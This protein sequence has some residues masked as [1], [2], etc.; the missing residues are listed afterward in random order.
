KGVFAVLEGLRPKVAVVPG[1]RV[2]MQEL[3]TVRIGGQ[4]TK[5]QYQFTLQSP[6]PQEL[7][8][9]AAELEG[10]MR[11]LSQL[12]DVTSDMQVENPE[13]HVD[14][15]RDKASRLGIS[16]EQI[17]SALYSAYGDRWISTIF[18]PNNQY[19]VIME[20]EDAYQADPTALSL[21]YVR[22]SGGQLVPLDTLVTLRRDVGPLTVNHAGQLPAV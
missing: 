18:A 22:A 4:L 1:I 13:V 20:L 12:R 19:R 15:D 14:I 21:L 7:Y 2:F 5:S 17:E 11:S 16:V 8:K 6:N 10:R 3:P 9:S